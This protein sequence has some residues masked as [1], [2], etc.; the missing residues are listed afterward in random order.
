MRHGACCSVRRSWWGPGASELALCKPAPLA[1][2]FTALP[3]PSPAQVFRDKEGR[4]VS[5]DEYLEQQAAAKKKAQYD[6]EAQL[7]WGGGLRQRQQAE[8]RARAMAEEAAKP[9]VRGRDPELDAIQK[10]VSRWGDPLAHLAK[11]R[12]PELEAPPAQAAARAKKLKKSGFIVPQEV[13]PHSWVRRGV[14]PPINRYNI[15]PGRHWDGVDRSNG[16]A[17][18]AGRRWAAHCPPCCM[19]AFVSVWVTRRSTTPPPASRH[20]AA[21]SETCSSA[22]TSSS[23]ARLRPSSW[24]RTTCEEGRPTIALAKQRQRACVRACQPCARGASHA[25][26]AA[27]ARSLRPRAACARRMFPSRFRCAV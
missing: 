24:R 10:R 25:A 17:L 1:D 16:C 20:C 7:A 12:E 19:R 14:G 13:P 9:F 23:S 5:R 11:R 22:R 6:S 3:P 18:P 2:A 21:L 15:R 4:A 26:L 8:E 27:A